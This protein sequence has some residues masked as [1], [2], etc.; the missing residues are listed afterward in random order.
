MGGKLVFLSEL[1]DDLQQIAHLDRN[2][3]VRRIY[4]YVLLSDGIIVHPAYIW[5][6]QPTNEL[7][8]GPLRQMFIPPVARTI[9]G[10]SNT[11]KEYIA[12]RFGRLEPAELGQTCDEYLKYKRWGR[13]LTDQ[14]EELDKIFSLGVPISLGQS[15]DRKFRALLK[16]DLSPNVNPDSLCSQ[17][18]RYNMFHE[19]HLNIDVVTS[20]LI[21]FVESSRL[22][23]LETFASYLSTGVGLRWLSQSIPF[24]K[25][26][27]N[28]YYHANIDEDIHVPGLAHVVDQVIDPFDPDVF[29]AVFSKLFG[30]KATNALC[31]SSDPSVV[32]V[33]L[34][35]RDSDEWDYCR[36]V[37]FSVLE[38]I[39]R[40]LW[41]NSTIIT[42]EIEEETEYL[43]VRVLR[44]IWRENKVSLAG[45]IFGALALLGGSVFALPF[46][47]LSIG[48]GSYH[49]IQGIRRFAFDYYN[50]E[51]IKVKNLIDVEVR[52]I[53]RPS[54]AK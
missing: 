52:H 10:D 42:R 3:L 25:R 46:G 38:K 50:N 41:Q 16:N 30:E 48:L 33:I 21:H 5:Q 28:L 37:Y 1:D 39:E 9:L 14:A 15:R 44:R 17:I 51:V 4:C 49:F 6:S 18:F 26:M 36:K 11:I 24:R 45:G 22:V 20:K 12:Q 23:S 31:N 27:L 29:W 53:L 19:L 40:S 35:I 47:L 43:N 13:D 8:F 2:S 7:V 32:R 54:K 34:K